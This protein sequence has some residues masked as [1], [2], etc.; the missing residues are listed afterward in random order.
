MTIGQNVRRLRLLHG[1]SQVALAGKMGVH[2]STIAYWE[3]VPGWS[4]DAEQV[5]GLCRAFGIQPNA[6]N[7][8]NNDDAA[9]QPEAICEPV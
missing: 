7:L 5:E 3:N 8:S 4:P 1:L 6:L 2:Q 9:S